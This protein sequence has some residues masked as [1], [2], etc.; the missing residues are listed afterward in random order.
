ML[1]VVGGL[2]KRNTLWISSRLLG[3][4]LATFSAA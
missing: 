1:R 4:L 2:L 3:D